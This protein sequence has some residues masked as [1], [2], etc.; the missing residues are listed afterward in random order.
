MSMRAPV[1]TGSVTDLVVTLRKDATPDS[2]NEAFKAAASD[3]PLSPY[4]E[5]SNDPLVS[6]DI[7]QSPHSCIFD[8]GLTMASGTFAKVF[9]WYDN[10]WGYSCRLVDLVAKVI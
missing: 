5:Y 6:T 7:V 4:L 2:V 1:P 8:S 10:E 9:G 3:G